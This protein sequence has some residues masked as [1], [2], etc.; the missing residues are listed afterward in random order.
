MINQITLFVKKY[1]ALI[2]IGFSIFALIYNII[3]YDPLQGYDAEAHYNYF[4][5]ISMY[6]PQSFELPSM[7]ITREFFNPPLPYLFPAFFQVICRNVITSADYIKD[8]SLAVGTATQFFQTMLYILT[9]LFYLKSFKLLKN[10]SRII[11]VNLILMISLLSVNYR[12][13]Q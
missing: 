5:F 7:E 6:L 9:F 3:H 13:F 4:Y 10:I 1:L 11:N 2:V 12:T 8:C